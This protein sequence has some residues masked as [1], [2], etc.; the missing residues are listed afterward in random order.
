MSLRGAW[1]R[2]PRT[3]TLT[4]GRHLSASGTWQENG[5]L[6]PEGEEVYRALEG[7]DKLENVLDREVKRMQ[8]ALQK[9]I[10][11]LKAKG[12]G[13]REACHRAWGSS[14]APPAIQSSIG[15]QG[16][17]VVCTTLTATALGKM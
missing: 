3:V 1:P 15:H 2:N 6:G 17:R 7:S 13:D 4:F 16:V 12:Y 5:S 11:E 8:E 14:F 10:E 9:L